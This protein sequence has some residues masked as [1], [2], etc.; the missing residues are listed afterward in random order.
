M[1]PIRQLI[2]GNK[3]TLH[4]LFCLGVMVLLSLVLYFLFISRF[5]FEMLP[6]ITNCLF[7]LLCI[8]IGRWL[9]QAWYLRNRFVPFIGFSVS[10]LV[11]LAVI[12]WL[13][14]MY[15]FQHPNAGF[16]EVLKSN[17]PFILAGVVL[18]ML[19]KL[20]SAS[21]QK[22]LNDAQIKAEQK[23]SEF[24]LL[25]SQLS[26]HFLFNVL[27][28][29]YGISIAEHERI[30]QLLLKLSNLLRY[31]V[32]GAKKTF[33]PLKDELEYIKNYIEF[34]QI[35]ISDRLNLVMEIPQ[36]SSPDIKIA[37][38]VLIVFVENAFKHSKNTFN[39]GIDIDISLKITGSFICFMVSNSYNIE[40]G[41]SDI[42][43]ESSGL[44]LANTIKR[45]NLLYG[46]DYELKQ[47]AENELYHVTLR[48]K[49]KE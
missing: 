16:R 46:N 38:Q 11:L 29:L 15:P 13:M 9:C 47:D 43:N 21:M 40:K 26:P 22:E 23:Q 41:V 25:Q 1:K 44:G 36:V 6:A 5:P 27:N 35:R 8:Y 3:L 31:S 32:Y 20:I 28:N 7:F 30:P 10:A 49:I 4:L 39:Q 45:L 2:S 19:L 18:G 24:N 17:M 48:L 37:P 33:V 12:E 34:E 14:V 42:L